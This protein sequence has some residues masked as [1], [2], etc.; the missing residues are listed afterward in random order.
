MLHTR[1]VVL[2]TRLH[3]LCAGTN[4]S[5]ATTTRRC[6]ASLL[7]M[8]KLGVTLLKARRGSGDM[9]DDRGTIDLDIDRVVEGGSHR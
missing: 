6:P 4:S 8:K 2:L 5:C 1:T 7:K 9:T 3:W